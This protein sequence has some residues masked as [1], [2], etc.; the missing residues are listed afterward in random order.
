MS[1]ITD[2]TPNAYDEWTREREAVP[3]SGGQDVMRPDAVELLA[4]ALEASNPYLPKGQPEY[5][6]RILAASPALREARSGV[7]AARVRELEE[8]LQRCNERDDRTYATERE[9]RARI[10]KL[11]ELL[12]EASDYIEDPSGGWQGDPPLIVDWQ[13]R[14]RALLGAG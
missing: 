7:T 9:L 4:E 5:A 1:D 14:L 13:A 10:A 12:W 8:A 11:T 6:E 2:L 3:P